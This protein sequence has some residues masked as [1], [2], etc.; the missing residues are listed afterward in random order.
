MP[1]LVTHRISNSF[2][3]SWEYPIILSFIN[4]KIQFEWRPLE[5][6]SI[7]FMW[8]KLLEDLVRED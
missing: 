5:A 1:V 7:L 8:T 6:F 2:Y 4:N 3:L